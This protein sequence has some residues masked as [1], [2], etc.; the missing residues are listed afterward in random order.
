MLLKQSN[1]LSEDDYQESPEK[2]MGNRLRSDGGRSNRCHD[3]RKGLSQIKILRF[4][5]SDDEEE[6]HKAMSD[7]KRFQRILRL[8]PIIFIFGVLGIFYIFYA[9]SRLNLPAFIIITILIIT[10]LKEI[11][12]LLF[13]YQMRK[14][15]MDPL[16]KMKRATEEIRQGNYGVV[17]D[18]GGPNLIEDLIESFND[19]SI[20]LKKANDMKE[21][22]ELNRKKLIAGISHDLK[23]PITSIIGYIDGI[24]SGVAKSEE[25][26]QQYLEIIAKN[27]GYTNQLIDDLFLFSKIDINQVDY[28]FQEIEAGEF[29]GDFFLEKKLELVEQLV[30]VTYNNQLEGDCPVK[31]DINLIVRVLSNLIQNSLKYNDKPK[32]K[33]GFLI[34]QEKRYLV[35][36]VIDNGIGIPQDELEDIFDV[37]YRSDKARNKDIGGTG[38]GLSI[39]KQLV[40]GHGGQIS[41]KSQLGVGTRM[42][43]RLPLLERRRQDAK[44]TDIDY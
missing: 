1:K 43:V 39:A 30:G 17:I 13:S 38:L 9:I 24:Q 40:E 29:F 21:K 42:E 11:S 3:S 4:F 22:Y 15:L 19:M 5:H 25:K 34:E 7:F 32:K 23:T 35:I 2:S 37:F 31:L 26:K 14:R 10:L 36:S 12:T 41:A 44:T 6:L 33:I 16:E 18:E 20:E 8:I 27:A 28:H